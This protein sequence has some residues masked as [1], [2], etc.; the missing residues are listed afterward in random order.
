MMT[1]KARHNKKSPRHKERARALY[2]S[3]TLRL[4]PS[5][6]AIDFGQ[7]RPFSDL[8]ASQL[9]I[10]N[11]GDEPVKRRTKPQAKLDSSG[12]RASIWIALKKG[13][14]NN[15]LRFAPYTLSFK[16]TRYENEHM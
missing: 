1:S 7:A 13:F 15:T 4:R 16:K 3:R 14:K 11:G 2:S 5:Q 6:T 8:T 12:T 10:A 9:R